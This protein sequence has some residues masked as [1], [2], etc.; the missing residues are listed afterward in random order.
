[1]MI[2][3]LVWVALVVCSTQLNL[4]AI[5]GSISVNNRGTL[6]SRGR[7]AQLSDGEGGGGGDGDTQ[8]GTTLS[9][10]SASSR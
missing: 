10:S 5:S 7:G 6:A 3:G 2:I 8:L 9:A 4:M 1:M